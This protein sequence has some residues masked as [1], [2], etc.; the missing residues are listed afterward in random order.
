M[1][2]TKNTVAASNEEAVT[3]K[4]SYQQKQRFDYLLP[5]YGEDKTTSLIMLLEARGRNSWANVHDKIKI[6][7][8]AT[9]AVQSYHDMLYDNFEEGKTYSPQQIIGI[10]ADVRRDMDLDPY[11]TRI[12]YNCEADLFN[13][14]IVQDVYKEVAVDSAIVKQL[15]GYKPVFKLKLED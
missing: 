1:S 10:V 2:K 8:H 5:V 9:H 14:F 13:L 7:N 3:F 6:V 4:M 15:V 11:I 12:K